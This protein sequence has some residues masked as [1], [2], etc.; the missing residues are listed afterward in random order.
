MERGPS[1]ARFTEGQEHS[2]GELVKMMTEQVSTLIHDEMKLAQVEM[3][4]MG[5]QAAMGAGMF[6]PPAWW[7]CTAWAAC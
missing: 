1:T 3:T 7:L 6:G 2:T 5:K 4:S